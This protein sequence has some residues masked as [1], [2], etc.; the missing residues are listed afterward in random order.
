MILFY[1]S[2]GSQALINHL[3]SLGGCFDCGSG[4]LSHQA[5]E[6]PWALPLV[7][8]SWLSDPKQKR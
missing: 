7:L 6:T 5:R 3:G 8:V 4:G 2:T 1:L